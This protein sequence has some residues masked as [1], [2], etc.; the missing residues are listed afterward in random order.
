MKAQNPENSFQRNKTSGLFWEY[1]IEFSSH[2]FLGGKEF[3]G[4]RGN[5]S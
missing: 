4:M 3:H 2:V 1:R 5:I